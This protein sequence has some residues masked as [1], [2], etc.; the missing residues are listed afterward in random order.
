MELENRHFF[1]A[2]V[3]VSRTELQIIYPAFKVCSLICISSR[4]VNFIIISFVSHKSYLGTIFS[5]QTVKMA[6]NFEV[7]VLSTTFAGDIEF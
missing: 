2:H 5:R 7:G 1:E 4:N 3:I 6:I